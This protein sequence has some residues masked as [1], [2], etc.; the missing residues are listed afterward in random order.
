MA[1]VVC[2]GEILVDLV[3]A[4]SGASLANADTL[5]K[6][7]GGAPANVAVGLARLGIASAFMGS[8][9]ADGFGRFLADT[10]AVEGVDVSGLRVSATAPT[11]LAAVSLAADGERDFIFYGTPAAH[12]TF[13][14]SDINE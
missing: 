3:P 7:A 4:A 14:P 12:T 2:L 9:G 11:A 1:D 13:A 10:L 8:V 5:V 6:A